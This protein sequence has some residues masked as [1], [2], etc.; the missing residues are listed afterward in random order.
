MLQCYY[1]LV[2]VIATQSLALQCHIEE[3][4]EKGIDAVCI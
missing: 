1:T 4:L 3:L 2:N